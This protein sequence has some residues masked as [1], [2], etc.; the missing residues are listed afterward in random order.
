MIVHPID[1][2]YGT[3]EMKRIWSEESKIKRMIRVEIALLKVLAKKGYLDESVVE[4]IKKNALKISPERV[5]EIEGEIKHDIMALVKAISE[6]AEDSR[7]I[8]FGATSND[9]IDTATATQLRDTILILESKLKKL[10]KI[11][12][13]KTIEYKDVVCLG[14]THGQAALP[15]TYGFRFAIWASEFTRHYIRLQQMK[16]RLLVGKLSGA[17]GTQAAYGEEGIEIEQEVMRLLNLKPAIISSQI[18]PRDIYCEYVEF[19]ANLASSLEKVA[20]NFRL[21]QRAEVGEVMEGFGKKQVGSSTMPH[22]RNP[23]DCENICGLAR[24][25]RGFVEPQH[26]SAIL[27]EER[28]LTNSSAERI[29]LVEASVLVDHILTK[30]INVIRNLGLNL[31]NIRRNLEAQRGLNMSEAVMIAL[32]KKGIDRQKAHEMLRQVSLKAY[33]N[34]TSLYEELIKNREIMKFF[35]EKE[36]EEILKPENYLG[37]TSKRIQMVVK[38]IE[39][40][41]GVET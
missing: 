7:W 15:T 10:I 30:M 23:I 17:V 6:V 34:N 38:W 25:V 18:I 20:L 4:K 14:R 16:D 8:H 9:I 37:T 19:L 22:K 13:D 36:L 41:L 35:T 33:E 1:Y 5:K 24:I 11:L 29:V 28:D 12:V 26:Q 3:P 32:T 2:R 39:D 40:I 31:E 27:W 21:L